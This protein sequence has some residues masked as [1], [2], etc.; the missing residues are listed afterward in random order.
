[1]SRAATTHSA[2][3]RVLRPGNGA[4]AE[5][6]MTVDDFERIRRSVFALCGI[7]LSAA[8]VDM[9]YNR[10]SRVLR[11]RRMSAFADYLDLLEGGDAAIRQEFI[12]A[13]TTNLTRFFR[14]AGHFEV[15]SKFLREAP[16]S[17]K[18]SI[19]CAGCSTGEEAY[20]I[21]VTAIEALGE[22][23]SS[24][25]VLATDVDTNVLATAAAG[26]YPLEAARDLDHARLR[27]LFLAGT[28]ANSGKIRVRPEVRAMVRFEQHNLRG[29][30]W[31]AAASVG[32]IFCRNVLIYFDQK[33]QAE[34]LEKFRA[35]LRPEGLLF[36]GHS[37]YY[38]H[39]A[40]RWTRIA[41]AVF[42]RTDPPGE[43]QRPPAHETKEHSP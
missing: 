14:E 43:M 24:V 32:A 34:V 15:L 36:S 2:G 18:L 33:S 30:T 1:M 35:C 4:G 22:R 23:A 6:V 16:R 25:R 31:P 5:F 37:E 38:A 39:S 17:E 21:A 19:W 10:L 3:G 28:G 26:I 12:N 7:S 40:H 20:T 9:A 42:R 27:R 13:M 11:A 8:K 29:T 41:H